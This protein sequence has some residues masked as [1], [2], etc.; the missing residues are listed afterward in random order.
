MKDQAVVKL[1]HQMIWLK[2]GLC[3]NLNYVFVSFSRTES[4]KPCGWCTG[5]CNTLW[6]VPAKANSTNTHFSSCRNADEATHILLSFI[7]NARD[8]ISLR[9][10]PRRRRANSLI[11]KRCGSADSNV[12]TSQTIRTEKCLTSTADGMPRSL[13][14]SLEEAFF[15]DAPQSSTA[16]QKSL[17]PVCQTLWVNSLLTLEQNAP[18][19]IL[20][21]LYF[22][23]HIYSYNTDL[24]EQSFCE[25]VGCLSA[26]QFTC[27]WSCIYYSIHHLS[28]TV[29]QFPL[30]H[31]YYF[32]F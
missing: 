2:I 3:K 19:H 13:A 21:Y 9:L 14:D 31:F 15:R 6:N 7:F 11:G 30:L 16:A 32:F 4:E 23:S 20:I 10:W 8:N 17:L 26:V 27:I 29:A 22:Q 5:W 18:P 25:N 24:Q 28:C 1:L 12:I